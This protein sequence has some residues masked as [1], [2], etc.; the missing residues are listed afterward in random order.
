MARLNNLDYAAL[1]AFGDNYLQWALDTKIMLKSKD[2]FECIE[3]GFE[4]SDKQK[5][6]AIMHMRHHL[7]ESLKNQYLII[8]DH[9]D[10]WT[11]LN[12][13]YGHQRMV[14][15]PKAQFDWKNLRIQDYK[16]VDEYNSELFRIVSLLR[17]CGTKVTEK[18]L[19]EKTLSTFSPNNILFQQQYQEKGFETYVDLILCLLLAEQNNEL[20]LMN[21]DMRP[22]GTAPLPEAHKVDVVK[23]NPN[24]PKEPKETNYVHRERHYGRGRGGRGRGG[25]GRGGRGQF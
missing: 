3:E 25:R 11:E 15:L 21:S 16:S 4:P 23:Q 7:A 24:E 13:R 10:L 18:E 9:F 5:Y 2:L 19:L 20:L 6:K 1:N 8:K 14:L 22:P 17:L 12:R